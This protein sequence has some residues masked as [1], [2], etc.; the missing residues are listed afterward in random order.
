MPTTFEF[1]AADGNGRLKPADR[2]RVKS[3]CS[4]GRN[5]RVDS[6]RSKREARKETTKARGLLKGLGVPPPPPTNVA[7]LLPNNIG[8][9]SRETLHRGNMN[10]LFGT[11][12]STDDLSFRMQKSRA[13]YVGAR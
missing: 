1:I 13:V 11:E 6:R 7:V 8:R 2:T 9:Q 12:T 10:N 4:Q 5:K 3:H